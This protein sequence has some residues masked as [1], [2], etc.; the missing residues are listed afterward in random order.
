VPSGQGHRRFPTT[1][2]SVVIAAGEQGSPKAHRALSELC[3]GYWRPVLAFVRQSGWSSDDAHDLTQA[4]FARLLEKGDYRHP[5]RDLGRF[6]DFLRTAVR[7][8]IAN[9]IDLDRALKRG[10]R[11]IHVPIG[12]AHAH[13]SQEFVDPAFGGTPESVYERQWAQTVLDR[14]LARLGQE[15]GRAGRKRVADGRRSGALTSSLRRS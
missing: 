15:C 7:H 13:G 10:G 1:H 5:R 3:E 6:R 4:F 14:S 11:Q 12:P 8:F 2:W 9:Q